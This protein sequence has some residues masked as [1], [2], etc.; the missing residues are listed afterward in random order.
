M[1]RDGAGAMRAELAR[2]TETLRSTT[3]RPLSGA[4][5]IQKLEHRARWLSESLGSAV[6]VDLR[7]Q[8][9]DRVCFGATVTVRGADGRDRRVRIVGVDEADPERGRVSWRSPLA[10]ALIRARVGDEV[11]FHPPDGEER[12]R[13]IRLDSSPE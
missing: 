2:I 7:E 5:E 13:V 1:T 12:L 11:I 6:V 10:K 4:G 8:L 3:R 9:P